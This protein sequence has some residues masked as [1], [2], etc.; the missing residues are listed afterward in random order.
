MPVPPLAEQRAI[1][2]YLDAETA[3]I[4]ALIVKKQQLIH[5]LD[6]RVDGLVLQ[7]ISGQLTSADA[8][9]KDSGLGWLGA[10]SSHFGTPTIG[11][12]F[13]TQLGKM[14]NADAASGSDQHRYIKNTNVKWDCFDLSNL[15]TMTFDADDRRRCELRAGDLLVCEG[16]EVGRSAIW[17]GSDEPVYFQKALHRV[18][19]INGASTRFLM[20]PP[21]IIGARRY[22]NNI[23]RGRCVIKTGVPQLGQGDRCLKWCVSWGNVVL[24][25]RMPCIY[26]FSGVVVPVRRRWCRWWRG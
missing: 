22:R 19:P 23:E 9:T 8:P 5:L 2:D 13:T 25:A 26:V 18:R 20:K 16:G 7:G 15:P 3:L 21:S 6:E 1:A 24:G 11:A 12:N 17:P 4:D 10:I 14:L